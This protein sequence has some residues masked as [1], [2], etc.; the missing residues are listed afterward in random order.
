M[1]K[2]VLI[3][4]GACGVGKTKTAK[5]WAKTKNGVTIECD[6]FREWEFKN[7]FPK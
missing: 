6:N 7:D 3:L 2:E 5:E 4:T 1:R